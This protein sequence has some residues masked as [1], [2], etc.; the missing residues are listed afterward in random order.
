MP[1]ISALIHAENDEHTLGRL[2]ETLRP[3]DE[4]IVVDHGSKDRTEKVAHEHGARVKKAVLGVEDGAYAVDCGNDWIL[5]LL[6]NESLSEGLEA[7]LFE[8]KET[9]PGATIGYTVNVRESNEHGWKK[10]GREL[11]LANRKEL[12]WKE[13]LPGNADGAPELNGDLLRF[14]DQNS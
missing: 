3:C 9:Q 12:N 1:K 14:A 6:P 10:L 13:R 8:W 7:A 2:L 4:V 11:R 5:C